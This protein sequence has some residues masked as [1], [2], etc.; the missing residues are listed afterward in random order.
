MSRDSYLRR[1]YGITEEEYFSILVEQGGV[2]FIC[3]QEPKPGQRA[4]AV[5]H[6]H[7]CKARPKHHP[8]KG[9]R[10]CV[11]GILCFWD[12]SKC[13][14]GARDNARHALR[15]AGYL[16][17][18]PAQRVL[19]PIESTRHDLRSL[20]IADLERMIEDDK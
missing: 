12:N 7:K 17:A 2:C 4:Y 11:R 14:K 3:G 15:T 20:T 13:V 1:T 6:D 19:N 9:C 10:S 8:K 16:M 5:D 18:P